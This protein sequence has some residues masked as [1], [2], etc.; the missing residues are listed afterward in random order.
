MNVNV[1]L[2]PGTRIEPTEQALLDDRGTVKEL[3][4]EAT[5]IITQGGSGG[6]N[7]SG[8]GGGNTSPR[9]DPPA[10]EAAR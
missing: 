5:T 4:P 10:A 9:P 2:A 8:G 7:W 1:E 6:N 3:V